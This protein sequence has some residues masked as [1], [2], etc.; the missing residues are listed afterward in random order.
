VEKKKKPTPPASVPG[1]TFKPAGSCHFHIVAR[2]ASLRVPQLP[3]DDRF[4][5]L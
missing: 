5:R 3:L 4:Y 2:I 1:T